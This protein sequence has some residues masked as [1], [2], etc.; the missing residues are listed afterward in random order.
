[1]R[2]KDDSKK[3]EIYILYNEV[4]INSLKK[5]NILAFEIDKNIAQI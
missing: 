1:M 5:E 4:N 3:S 2:I